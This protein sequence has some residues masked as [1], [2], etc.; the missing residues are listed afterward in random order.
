MTNEGRSLFSEHFFH[1][2]PLPLFLFGRKF[3]KN[4][5]PLCVFPLGGLFSPSSRPKATSAACCRIAAV[6]RGVAYYAQP[7]FDFPNISEEISEDQGEQHKR[8]CLVKQQQPRGAIFAPRGKFFIDYFK[9]TLNVYFVLFSLAL[10]FFIIRKLRTSKTESFHTKRSCAAPRNLSTVVYPLRKR[11]GGT[12]SRKLSEN[13]RFVR[14]FRRFP[15]GQKRNLIRH[16]VTFSL[17]FAVLFPV[18]F[19]FLFCSSFHVRR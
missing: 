4:G 8:I 11:L 5:Q 6:M 18:H 13:R 17:F 19:H 9:F 1:T 7:I 12:H 2:F 14:C 10:C 15:V 16:A 3:G